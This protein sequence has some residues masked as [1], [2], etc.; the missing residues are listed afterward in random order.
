[1]V[2]TPLAP[3]AHLAGV[4]VSMRVVSA[5]SGYGYLLRSVVQGDGEVAQATGFTRYFTEAGTPPGVWMGK[6]VAYFG[7][8]ELRPGMTVTPEH[9]Q[10]LLGRG[11]DPITGESLGQPFREYPTVAERT[12]AL[13]SRIDRAL[14]AE[15]FDTEVTRIQAE[16][17]ARG[18]QTATAGFDLTF[19]VPKSVSVLWGVADATTQE[20]IVEAHHVAVAQVLD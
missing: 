7:T 13:I 10:G 5:G 11:N 18:P 1:M 17:A 20:L 8:G 9:L 4:T 14:P 6:G 19:S 3:E 2:F 15:E 16:Q 12:A